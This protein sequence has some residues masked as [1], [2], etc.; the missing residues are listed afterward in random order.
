MIERLK[1]LFYDMNNRLNGEETFVVINTTGEPLTANQ[2]LKP[3]IIKENESYTR[4]E[5]TENGQAIIHTTAET[6]LTHPPK[7][8]LPSSIAS[9][10]LRTIL[11]K[12]GI[13]IWKQK[14]MISR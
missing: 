3:L 14:T 10:S 11:K 7:A 8:C 9:A 12:G 5:Q 2:N 4:E 1:F 6:T 13:N